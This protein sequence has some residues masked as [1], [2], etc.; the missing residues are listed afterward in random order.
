MKVLFVTQ[1]I[2]SDLSD[3]RRQRI[4]A[5]LSALNELGQ[6]DVVLV[7]CINPCDEFPSDLGRVISRLPGAPIEK[8]IAWFRRRTG[9]SPAAVFSA[10][11]FV[12]LNRIYRPTTDVVRQFQRLN[13][14]SYDIVFV[15]LLHNAWSLGWSDT[16]RT[17]VDLDDIPSQS[18]AAPTQSLNP[19]KKLLRGLRCVRARHV[20]RRALDSF[21]LSLVCSESDVSY[22][23][24][25]PRVSVLPN[26]YWPHPLMAE[27]P[28]DGV[29][30]LMLYVGYLGYWRLRG[31]NWFAEQVMPRVIERLPEARLRVIGRAD[32]GGDMKWTKAEG[33]DYLGEQSDI[34]PHVHAAQLQIC[35]LLEGQGT[36]IKIAECLA[37]GRPIVSTTIGAYGL[38]LTEEQ[39]VF[40]RDDAAGFAEA[41]IELLSCPGRRRACVVAGRE[42][43]GERFS[44]EAF[45][46]RL[47]G[48]VQSVV[49]V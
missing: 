38:P 15:S 45:K 2:P 27:N 4:A 32:K 24:R 14:E 29:N 35:P 9:N 16:A 28:P 40:R 13:P 26:C 23:C 36:R 43:V 19:I 8:N 41:I 3:G 10:A 49:A 7:G 25:H 12:S 30:G 46:T 48:L 42:L 39:G 47:K 20:E 37:F 22:L 17:I 1:V 5:Q 31:L 21:R 18:F 34:G 44:L 11:P 33:V 6:V